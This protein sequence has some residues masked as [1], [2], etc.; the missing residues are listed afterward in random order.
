M[1]VMS[2][3]PEPSGCPYVAKL[4]NLIDGQEVHKVKLNSQIR[5]ARHRIL[6]ENVVTDKIY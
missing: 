4:Q 6:V 1:M 2:P 5:Q 3:A